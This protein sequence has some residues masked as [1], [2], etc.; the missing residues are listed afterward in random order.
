MSRGGA[1]AEGSITFALA[2]LA[3]PPFDE[4]A[5]Q[6]PRQDEQCRCLFKATD[7]TPSRTPSI[8]LMLRLAAKPGSIRATCCSR[9]LDAP[10]TLS[11]A[12]DMLLL[13]RGK[14]RRFALPCA[15]LMRL[16]AH[17]DDARKMPLTDFCNRPFDTRTRRPFNSRARS[18][19]RGDRLHAAHPGD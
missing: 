2:G 6:P 1:Y 14:S 13:C 11:S 15:L 3:R 5:R 19:R 10:S 4:R 9:S 7:H 8:G 12:A 18:S 17:L 16:S